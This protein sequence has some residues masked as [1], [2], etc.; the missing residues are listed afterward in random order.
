MLRMLFHVYSNRFL[1]R[2][3]HEGVL[4]DG[5]RV[6][7]KVQYPGVA[8]GI[9]SDINNLVSTLN[10]ANIIPEQFFVDNVIAVAK[11]ELAWECDYVRERECGDRFVKILAPYSQYYVPRSIPEVCT[12]RV[13]TTELID[14]LPVDKCIDADQQTR[15]II[16]NL[17]LEL[18]IRELFE[19]GYMQTDPNW[20]NFIY[21]SKTQQIVLLDFGACRSYD[22][23]FVDVYIEIIHGAA[24]KD[25]E[26]V[27]HYSQE[28]G[29][30]TGHE[31]RV[32]L[33]TVNFD[34]N[35][36]TL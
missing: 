4:P 28:I 13:L 27:R 8:E 33:Q 30:L 10:V 2:Q 25:R 5:R 24:I 34:I 29:F 36:I 16:S 18:T 20:A 6:A 19:F 35:Y 22:K 12:K 17:I 23:S 26:K 7:V 1:L 11:R 15:D 32:S 21:N 14:G 3:V 31:A 9:E